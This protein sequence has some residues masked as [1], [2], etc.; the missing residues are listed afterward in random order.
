M[1]HSNTIHFEK[2]SSRSKARARVS[3][4]VSPGVFLREILLIE[5]SNGYFIQWPERIG[6]SDS[7]NEIRFSLISFASDSIRLEWEKRIVDGY[8]IWKQSEA[9]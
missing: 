7:G 2:L 8:Q 1:N 5:G 9:F 6:I 4:C 3:I